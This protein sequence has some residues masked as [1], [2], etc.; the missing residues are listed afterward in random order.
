MAASAAA[1]VRTSARRGGRLV[2]EQSTAE[3]EA[4]GDATPFYEYCW[5]HTT[6]QVLKRERG[7]F[8]Y[9]QCRFPGERMAESIA[10]VRARF[11]DEVWL[12]LEAAR[13][14]GVQAMSG[15]PVVRWTTEERLNEIIAG[16][17][18]EGV[19]IANPHVWTLE[20]GSAWK[21]ADGDQLGFK[22]RVDPLGLLNP[23]K[24]R[25]FTPGAP[26]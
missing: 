15:L 20:D 22:H 24:M 18:A 6:L 1:W 7:N 4:D 9:L 21:R 8:T 5:N 25:S 14:A 2:A 12:H 26:M 16:F 19:G 10:A 11:G 13:F 3:A 17:E 23:G